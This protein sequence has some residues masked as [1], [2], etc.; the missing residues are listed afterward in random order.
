ML[1]PPVVAEWVKALPRIQVE[2]HRRSQVE[3][4]AW[5][6]FDN[7]NSEQKEKVFTIQPEK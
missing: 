3:N 4:P 6:N 7:K 1:M 5:D 2:A